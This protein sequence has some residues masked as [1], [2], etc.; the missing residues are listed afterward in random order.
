MIHTRTPHIFA[1][2]FIIF[3]TTTLS[4]HSQSKIRVGDKIPTITITD[5]VANKPID[6]DLS[7]KFI[8]LDFWAT[9]CAPCLKAVPHVDSIMSKFSDR[10]D[11]YFISIS[12]ENVSKAENCLKRVHMKS[13]VVVDTTRNTHDKMGITGIPVTIL[14]DNNGIIRWIGTPD[15]LDSVTISDLLQKKSILQANKVDSSIIEKKLQQRLELQSFVKD[16]FEKD[17]LSIEKNNNPF[18]HIAMEF[19]LTEKGFQCRFMAVKL[20]LLITRFLKISKLQFKLP[21]SLY[22]NEYQIKYF[23]SDFK[24]TA[25]ESVNNEN[26]D[27]ARVVLI[28]KIIKKLGLTEKVT[29]KEE[30]VYTV[31]T[32]INNKLKPVKAQNMSSST[33]NI[34][35]VTGM[36]IPNALNFISG[37]SKLFFEDKTNLLDSY[38]LII[39]NDSKERVLKDLEAY[40]FKLTKTKKQFKFLSFE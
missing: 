29:L 13:I 2:V 21:D 37:E 34:I 6:R 25:S 28:N 14:A 10:K 5:Y 27:R 35:I 1:S 23:N 8:V 39:H 19:P 11:L 36:N 9:W 4:L 3:M 40:G 18:N 7:N 16:L 20:E 26:I 32:T 15:K 24:K 17:S 31:E 38:D 30:D 22:S 12:D 33:D